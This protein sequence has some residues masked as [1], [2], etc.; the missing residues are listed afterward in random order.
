[1]KEKQ[2]IASQGQQP[3]PPPRIYTPLESVCTIETG[4]A[5]S[6]EPQCHRLY[7]A[8]PALLHTEIA[9]APECDTL[10]FDSNDTMEHI[11]KGSYLCQHRIAHLRMGS[12][13]E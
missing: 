10:V 13:R 3:C 5:F 6:I 2:Q 11:M 1:M 8:E 12:Q 4:T 7:V 9:V